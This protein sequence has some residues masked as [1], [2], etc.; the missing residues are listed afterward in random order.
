M[1]LRALSFVVCV[2]W[3]V[4]ARADTSM[5]AAAAAEKLF[6]EGRALTVAG[7]Y[8]QACPKFAE[9]LRLD[10]AVGTSLNLAECYEKTGQLASAWVTFRS[11]ANLAKRAG[12]QER[13]VHAETRAAA[14]EAELSYITI[15]VEAGQAP[16]FVVTRDS[17]VLG[18]AAWGTPVPIDGGTH[19][20][21]ARA[22]GRQ[23]FRQQIEVAAREA[24]V[25]VDIARLGD[26]APVSVPVH[27][28]PVSTARV[29]G[30]SALGVGALAVGGGLILGFVAKGKN[31]SAGEHCSA[32]D[33]DA[34]GVDLT[35][36]ASSFAG[37][38]TAVV[39]VGA[40]F[41]A[42]GLLLTLLSPSKAA[43]AVAMGGS[44]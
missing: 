12:Q 24:H 14:L 37:A 8:A 16:G 15:A 33:C 19:I 23:P 28:A 29:L 17:E 41:V 30:W 40:V 6:Q 11:T 3:P 32:V 1:K 18:E 38:S 13:M 25:T 44:F 7:N 5:N 36:Q 35:Q 20:V 27:S 9:S 34:R 21:E 42:G 31:D 22:P 39:T 4:S 10:V 43:R 2:A 26:M